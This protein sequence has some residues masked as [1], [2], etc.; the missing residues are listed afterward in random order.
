M[1]IMITG[2]M[3]FIG[4]HLCEQL[5]MEK[6][7][8]VVLTKSFLK[9]HNIANISK[10]IKIEKIDVTDFKRLGQSIQKNKPNVII[11]LAGQ[12]S[13][14]Q[15]FK[16]PLNDIDSNAK[17]TLFI[18]EEIRKSKLKCRFILGS[19][20]I[21]IGRPQKIPIDEKTPCWPTTVYGANRLASEHYCKIYH[22]VYGLDTVTF[23][24]T[25][26]F[27]PREQ[28]IPTK[29]AVN[30]LIYEAFKGNIITIFKKGKFFRDLIYISDVISGIKTIMKKGKSGELYWISSGKKIWFYELAKLLEKLTNAKVKFVKTPNYTKKVDVG[31]F[32]VNNSKLRSLGWKP[33]MNLDQGI[34]K[35]LEY[36]KS[37]K[38]T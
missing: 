4:S 15:S 3:G 24:I 19:T 33:K 17:S 12:T 1:K 35:T 20:F 7:D 31:N 11:H 29:N 32:V 16:Q 8:L 21:V 18:L 30:F 13:H 10:K 22:E 9:K 23:R 25:N 6:H 38:I 5:L 27:G 34:K 26:S 28:V 2:G 36:F 37:Q 14:S